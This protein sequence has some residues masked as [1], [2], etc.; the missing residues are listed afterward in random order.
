MSKKLQQEFAYVIKDI[1]SN[2]SFKRLKE[3]L[4]HGISRYEHS[5]RVARFTYR[6]TRL[7][8]MKKSIESTRAALLHDFYSDKDLMCE[9]SFKKLSLHPKMA[10]D[11]SLKYFE[12]SELQKDI[13][14]NHMFPCTFCLPKYKES[15]LVSIIDKIVGLYEMLR[16]K[17]ALY[18]GIYFLFIV[19]LIK[20]SEY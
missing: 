14:V 18:M 16:Y 2:D 7:F 19:E 11:N 15:W 17:I 6:F 20:I 13:I 3:E 10:L 12:L 8:K 9:T 1:K 5:M 4:H